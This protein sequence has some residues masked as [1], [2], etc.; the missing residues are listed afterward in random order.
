MEGFIKILSIFI[1]AI[2]VYATMAVYRRLVYKCSHNPIWRDLIP[3]WAV[4]IGTFLMIPFYSSV[5]EIVP[6]TSLSTAMLFGCFSGLAA[7]GVN[8]LVKHTFGNPFRPVHK[9]I[10]VVVKKEEEKDTSNK[11]NEET[12]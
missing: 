12:D 4:L 3:L 1:V 8:Q 5:P 11:G 6:A 2:I 10:T 7:V 9:E